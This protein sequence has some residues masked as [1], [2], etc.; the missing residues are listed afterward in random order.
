MNKEELI[1]KLK[2]GVD[3]KNIQLENLDLGGINLKGIKLKNSVLKNI[4]FDDA[5]LQEADLRS[6]TFTNCSFVRTNLR[7]A[8]LR[9]SVSNGCN[10]TLAI[11]DHGFLENTTFSNCILAKS[12]FQSC[13][14]SGASFPGSTCDDVNFNKANLFGTVLK[15]GTFDKANFIGSRLEKADFAKSR[16]R[17]AIFTG[18]DLRKANLNFADFTDTDF[19]GANLEGMN[20][21]G[22]VFYGANF[23]KAKMRRVTL[24]SADLETAKFRASDLSEANLEKAKMSHAYMMDAKLIKTNLTS[25]N[26]YKAYLYGAYLEEVILDDTNL[27]EADL[28]ASTLKNIK[29]N[30]TNLKGTNF[31]KTK[32][33][34]VGLTGARNLFLTRWPEKGVEKLNHPKLSESIREDFARYLA[35]RQEGY[36]QDTTGAAARETLEELKNIY[37]RIGLIIPLGMYA[38]ALNDLAKFVLDLRKTFDEFDEHQEIAQLNALFVDIKELYEGITDKE[39]VF[40]ELKV[41]QDDKLEFQTSLDSMQMLDFIDLVSL[42]QEAYTSSLSKQK[43]SFEVNLSSLFY[44]PMQVSLLAEEGMG[45]V[46]SG[47]AKG[48]VSIALVMLDGM[49]ILAANEVSKVEKIIKGFASRSSKSESTAERMKQLDAMEREALSMA[50]QK[51]KML[52]SLLRNIQDAKKNLKNKPLELK[53][54]DEKFLMDI[55]NFAQQASTRKLAEKYAELKVGNRIRLSLRGVLIFELITEIINAPA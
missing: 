22:S 47:N 12:S 25:A 33:M 6:V 19:T 18:M 44:A 10:F 30:N 41:S 3:L 16:V 14:L 8:T 38:K 54:A 15:D 26:L 31:E 39:L 53:I 35:D 43:D 32:M 37:I 1:A 24:R 28:Q 48:L 42:F 36:R 49:K 13:D 50:N 27:E 7:S 46:M 45:L 55:D 52:R 21:M 5:N 2:S 34:K 4:R 20:L 23:S 40:D 11:F 9:G 17:N 29:C 51:H